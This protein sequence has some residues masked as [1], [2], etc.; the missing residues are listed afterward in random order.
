MPFALG[1]KSETSRNWASTDDLKPSKAAT[2]AFIS[3]W[4]SLP[5]DLSR[6]IAG[7]QSML[8][9]QTCAFRIVAF[10]TD[11]PAAVDCFAL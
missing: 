6:S 11:L 7:C 5:S 4:P 9:N 3:I 10:E 2:S 8:H 1:Y